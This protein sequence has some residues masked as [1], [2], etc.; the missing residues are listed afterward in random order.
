MQVF[1]VQDDGEG[2]V[3]KVS[4]G[5][6]FG[7]TS[8]RVLVLD[9]MTGRELAIKV[10][11]YRHGVIDQTLP[12]TSIPLGPEWALQHPQ[13]YLDVLHEGIPAAMRAARI[14]PSQVV[15]MGID[16]T[17]CTVLPVDAQGRPLCFD[18]AW[19]SNPHAWPKLWKHHAA[20]RI[21]ERML[22]IAH[23][24]QE[25]FLL[26]Y[27]GR[28][29]SEGYF[30]KLIQIFEE[31]PAVYREM[32]RFIEV[33]DWIVWYLTG[34]ERRN[35]CMAGY[36]ALWSEREGFPEV[37]YFTSVAPGFTDPQAKLGQAF[38]PLG[39]VA[40][41]VRRAVA[42][43]L[44]LSSQVAVAVGNADAPVAVPAVGVS[45]P[46][47]L[48]MVMGT[49]ICHL[50][51]SA[52]EVPMPGITG[53]VKDGVLPGWYGYDAGQAAAGDMLD[54]FA[55]TAV[56]AA[57]EAEA[58]HAGQSL[59]AY[60][61]ARAEALR[62]GESGLLALDWWNGNRSI[63]ADDEVSG[64]IVG[65]TLSTTVEAQYRALLESVAMG[66]RRILENFCQH[67]IPIT[68]LIACGG[69]ADKNPLLLQICADVSGLPITVPDSLEIPARGA[70]LFGAVAARKAHGGFDSIAEASNV[71][72]APVRRRYEPNAEAVR[73]Y[74]EIYALYVALY[75]AF[76]GSRRD[77]LHRLKAIRFSRLQKSGP[78]AKDQG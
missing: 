34:N 51:V 68:Q 56:S 75:D 29:S 27:G 38:Y 11:P 14:A 37:G 46:S 40:G 35:G 66:T 28:I 57:L 8:G 63:L 64:V 45:G 67:G 6:D 50:T 71:L 43:R 20:Q 78:M 18:P 47:T 42:H 5:V 44:D 65:L 52:E 7:T 2:R 21:A 36:K 58:Q 31:A 1:S 74:D 19:A 13:D 32:Y 48:V 77:L 41:W 24:R 9:L 69:L 76:G 59:Y 3:G 62:P 4:L 15:G 22:Q 39:Q 53:V 60:L 55:R 49:S 70:A 23:E 72:A 26:R 73:Q 10:I 16:G 12:G 17:T 54:W 25:S 61:A 33:T 30:P